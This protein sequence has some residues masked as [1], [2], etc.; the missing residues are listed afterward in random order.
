MTT[1]EFGAS[2]A[3]AAPPTG[4][5]PALQGL[6]H[7]AQ[8][9]WDKAH[10]AVQDEPGPEAAWVHAYLHRKEGDRFNASYWY[11]RAGKNMPSCPLGQEWQDMVAALLA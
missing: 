2:L 6:W 7:D 10:E 8:G 5:G 1:D 4:L 3:G 9:D 11:S